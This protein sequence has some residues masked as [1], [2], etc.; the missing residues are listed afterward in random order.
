MSVPVCSLFS[1]ILLN[2]SGSA[3]N[4]I[5]NINNKCLFFEV[6]LFTGGS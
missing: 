3:H 6:K 4:K 5:Q 2:G 1:I